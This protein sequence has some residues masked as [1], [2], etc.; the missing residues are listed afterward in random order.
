MDD[1]TEKRENL[2]DSPSAASEEPT[3]PL[4]TRYS[5]SDTG[6]AAEDETTD[7]AAPAF[8]P[9]LE[10]TS[11]TREEDTEAEHAIPVAETVP[12]TQPPADE[13]AQ[14]TRERILAEEARTMAT[15][16]DRQHGIGFADGFRFGCGFFVAGCL[17]WILISLVLGVIP[18]VLQLLDVIALPGLR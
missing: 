11:T 7:E 13:L 17:F 18:F 6:S 8:E 1:T 10:E 2:P 5:P 4:E 16:G 9:H 3:G 14:A 12:K 15:P